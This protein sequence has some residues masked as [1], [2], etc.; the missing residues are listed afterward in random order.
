MRPRVWVLLIGDFPG[1]S[2]GSSWETMN[3]D[4]PKSVDIVESMETNVLHDEPDGDE[5][6]WSFLDSTEEES[7]T[8][9]ML[10]GKLW[11]SRL[12]N[13]PALIE[14]L[15]RLWQSKNG[16]EARRIEENLYSFQFFHWRDKMRVLEGQPWHFDKHV[17]CFSEIQDDGK[18]SQIQLHCLP[19]W[20]GFYNLPFKGRGSDHN[21]QLLAEKIGGFIKID[22]TQEMDIDRSIRVNIV[23]DVRHPLKDHVKLK[24][25][26][27]ETLKIPVKYERLP[28]FCYI[29]GRI[30]HS[31]RDCEEN[32]GDKTPEK[33]Y[34]T[35]LRAS[36]WKVFKHRGDED[37]WRKEG[38]AKRLFFLRP[39][40]EEQEARWQKVDK[41]LQQF[42]GVRID[43]EMVKG[44]RQEEERHREEKGRENRDVEELT[45]EK[46]GTNKE[47]VGE[48][49]NQAVV[50][51]RENSGDSV[52]GQNKQ[53]QVKVKKKAS[54]G[55]LEETKIVT[56]DDRE[57]PNNRKVQNLEGERGAVEEI[58]GVERRW[59][60][61]SRPNM[62]LGDDIVL[63]KCGKRT[64]E[65]MQNSRSE[66]AGEKT[67]PMAKKKCGDLL[68][69]K[70]H[71]ESKT[72]SVA[73][74]T[75][76]ALGS[77]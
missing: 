48:G 70:E 9:L 6:E 35:S 51:S 33:R 28:M 7:K 68:T 57:S 49:N 22:K 17:L 14:T 30:G 38:P 77:Q 13:A 53:Q 36:P 31:E 46:S 1:I 47:E 20:T 11:T 76:R 3:T 40:R 55:N 43:R 19:I 37:G 66:V 65:T 59:L 75:H 39:S 18:P 25:R 67:S 64:H 69:G 58:Q 15:T 32:R 34:N 16:I 54:D 27:G 62:N 24:V 60:R 61:I 74:P 4:A 45:Q 42:E 73:G 21:I 26:G 2:L 63:Q 29:C 44:V 50:A 12:I 71:M 72:M 52:M 10:I 23:V 5:V 8:S 56:S 41:V